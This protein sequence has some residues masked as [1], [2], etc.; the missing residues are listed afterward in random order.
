MSVLFCGSISVPEIYTKEELEE[1]LQ[2]ESKASLLTSSVFTTE[3]ESAI[4]KGKIKLVKDKEEMLKGM[5]LICQKYTPKMMDYFNIAIGAGLEKTNIYK[6]EIEEITAKRKKF[7][8]NGEEMKCGR[9][10]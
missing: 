2:K 5:R 9:L 8:Q 6:I 10:E 1:I 3:F 7:D 4:V